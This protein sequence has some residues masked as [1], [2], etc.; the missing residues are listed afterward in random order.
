LPLRR[1]V[2][3]LRRKVLPAHRR[4]LPVRR[5]VLPDEVR[6]AMVGLVKVA[7]AAIG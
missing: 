1:K 4:V 3:P 2:L 7:R 6:R 5:K